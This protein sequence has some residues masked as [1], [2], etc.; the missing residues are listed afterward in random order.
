MPSSF[1]I[2]DIVKSG[3]DDAFSI[4]SDLTRSATY[5]RVTDY[6]WNSTTGALD[7][8]TT[9]KACSL[10]V[11][12]YEPHQVNA[13]DILQGDE[14]IL[15]RSSELSGITPAAEDYI[16]ESG[17]TRRNL[18]AVFLD[19]STKLYE[20]QSRLETLETPQ[21]QAGTVL[22]DFGNLNPHDEAEGYGSLAA[23]FDLDDWGK[24]T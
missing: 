13:I 22:I 18:K 11:L 21:V 5:Y 9:T 16:I 3:L 10:F 7:P 2:S 1:K 8:I 15:I 17:G 23:F 12:P 20:F 24:L 19:P 6:T 14:R 4:A